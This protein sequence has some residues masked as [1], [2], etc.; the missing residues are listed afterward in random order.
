MIGAVVVVNSI[1][2]PSLLWDP[3]R[4]VLQTER[5]LSGAWKTLAAWS[6]STPG[7][8]VLLLA[9]LSDG[10]RLGVR[11]RRPWLLAATAAAGLLSVVLAAV[12]ASLGPRVAVQI[13]LALSLTFLVYTTL[14]LGAEVAQ[15]WG[16]P[17]AVATVYLL[18]A[19]LGSILF[20]LPWG[21]T[22]AIPPLWGGLGGA[23]M[24]V[25]LCALVFR[26]LRDEPTGGLSIPR[27]GAAFRALASSR[28][29]WLAGLLLFLLE[30]AQAGASVYLGSEP[31]S[32]RPEAGLWSREW[33]A[34]VL[35]LACPLYLWLC[36]RIAL[37]R[38]L[39]IA[40]GLTTLALAIQV[41]FGAALGRW[42]ATSATI[43]VGLTAFP[44][45]N[46]RFRVTP[47]GLEAFG[48]C[49]LFGV[50]RFGR[51]VSYLAWSVVLGYL[52]TGS[53]PM[54]LAA[55]SL[56]LSLA[57]LIPV[58]FLPKAAVDWAEGSPPEPEGEEAAESPLLQ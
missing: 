34:C 6:S 10:V 38:Q 54:V 27:P 16:L 22:G 56:G 3:V 43:L 21:T 13:P 41:L 4:E 49:L 17:G 32:A 57:A 9:L 37:R 28:G 2:P 31:W 52:P 8:L 58:L 55:A 5:S 26:L 30:V 24:L 7:F 18:S 33:E 23:L 50:A 12:P 29:F 48:L 11:R 51:E 1:V 40:A 36:R 46:L 39:L 42:S 19:Q 47:R 35:L 14:G 53:R 15:R 20:L 44:L 45:L 25:V